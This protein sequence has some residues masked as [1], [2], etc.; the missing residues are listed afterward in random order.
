MVEIPIPELLTADGPSVCIQSARA[1]GTTLSVASIWDRSG[2]RWHRW[3]PC[4]LSAL[5]YA[6]EQADALGLLLFDMR[7]PEA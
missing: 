4:E 1:A 5:A 3:Y 7:E 6:V 2:R